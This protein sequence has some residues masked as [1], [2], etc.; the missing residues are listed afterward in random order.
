MKN[1]LDKHAPLKSKVIRIIPTVPWFDAEYASL[2]RQRR[3]AEK[4]FRRSKADIDKENYQAIR[5]QTTSLALEKKRLFMCEKLENNSNKLYSIVDK[6]LD[7]TKETVLPKSESDQFRTF[8]SKKIN[9]IRSSIKNDLG[10][11]VGPPA[12]RSYG[13]IK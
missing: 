1:V 9:K 10:E 2:R 4:K 7:N 13:P 11:P 3:K 5:K 6:I 12:S 8:F